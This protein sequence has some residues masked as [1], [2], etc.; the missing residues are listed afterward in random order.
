[1]KIERSKRLRLHSTR[2]KVEKFHRKPRRTANRP[3]RPFN[4]TYKGIKLRVYVVPARKKALGDVVI[5]PRIYPYFGFIDHIDEERLSNGERW[6]TLHFDCVAAPW[7]VQNAGQMVQ[8]GF[9]FDQIA[10]TAGSCIIEVSLELAQIVALNQHLVAEQG[11]KPLQRIQVG[12]WWLLG[13]TSAPVPGSLPATKYLPHVFSSDPTTILNSGHEV[14]TRLSLMKVPD[15]QHL[16]AL[17]A[18]SHPGGLAG[19]YPGR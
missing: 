5:V 8:P 1:M 4:A 17:V 19:R 18:V 3:S 2:M 7:F 13:E 9:A 6:Y 10:Q 15:L 12:S 14:A 11:P 16:Q